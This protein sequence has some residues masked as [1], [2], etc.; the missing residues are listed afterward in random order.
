MVEG[1]CIQIEKRAEGRN[2][3]QIQALFILL[4]SSRSRGFLEFHIEYFLFNSEKTIDLSILP[5]ITVN[6]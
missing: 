5:K 1:R 6:W 3:P 4:Q 2:F